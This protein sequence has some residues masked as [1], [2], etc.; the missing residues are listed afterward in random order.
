MIKFFFI[1]FISIFYCQNFSYS[2]D[3]WF[4]ITAPQKIN[5]IS[6]SNEQ[7]LLSSNNGLFGYDIFN[8]NFYFIDDAFKRLDN[9]EV[10]IIFYDSYRDHLW[11]LNKEA[12][13]FK[14]MISDIWREID[15]YSNLNV[16]NT[17]HILN[18]GSNYDF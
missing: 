16:I 1:F 15:L 2:D 10:Y 4:T 9:H 13:Y 8:E 7:V 6:Y 5:S 12:I 17:N 18:I 14:S 11:L 3:D